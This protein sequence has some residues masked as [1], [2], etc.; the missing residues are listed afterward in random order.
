MSRSRNGGVPRPPAPLLGIY[1]STG[2]R[3]PGCDSN[4]AR[5]E[6]ATNRNS[7]RR[8]V[9]VLFR[10]ANRR[11]L[12]ERQDETTLDNRLVRA[13]SGAR[14]RRHDRDWS[15]RLGRPAGHSGESHGSPIPNGSC[16]QGPGIPGPDGLPR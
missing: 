4:P 10:G 15:R 16:H 3:W 8:A 5:E 7:R 11:A 12:F 2:M 14:N 1:A 6:P 9:K 13:I